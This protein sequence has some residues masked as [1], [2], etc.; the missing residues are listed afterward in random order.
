[1]PGGVPG[2]IQYNDG[3]SG[4]LDTT[5]ASFA[6]SANF[7]YDA[8]TGVSV[9]AMA[10]TD[11]VSAS[12]LTVTNSVSASSLTVTGDTLSIN[13]VNYKYP[14]AGGTADNYLL[15]TDAQN[16]LSWGKTRAIGPEGSVQ[17]N[18]GGAMSG[19]AECVLVGHSAGWS[20]LSL[21]GE[22][23]PVT[24]GSTFLQYAGKMD[25]PL[26]GVVSTT[27]NQLDVRTI[28]APKITVPTGVTVVNVIPS[29]ILFWANHLGVP[30]YSINP[31][32]EV[33]QE[34]PSLYV[35]NNTY[36]ITFAN[37]PVNYN[38]SANLPNELRWSVTLEVTAN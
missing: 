8:V 19:S 6:G 2:S 31:D 21:N 11:S 13:N 35:V 20:T 32:N 5:E 22:S 7:T 16:S 24:P 36:S 38:I 3:Q 26:L 10:V 25:N 28:F 18:S 30:L 12:S 29:G 4:L 23:V 33:I 34:G 15:T 9:N 17:V 14:A 37:I 27:W 1:L